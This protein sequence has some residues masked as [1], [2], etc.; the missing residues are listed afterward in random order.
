MKMIAKNLKIKSL[1]LLVS[2]TLIVACATT[3]PIEPGTWVMQSP[4]GTSEL[5]E[6][7]LLRD[8]EYYL[9]A[10]GN[11]ISGVYKLAQTDLKVVQPDNPRMSGLVWQL[12]PDKT[13]TL[14]QEA[15]V[16]ISSRRLVSA[17]LVKQP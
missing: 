5:V 4:D 11:P 8:S 7:R 2:A 16:Q 1:G 12:N 17:T 13:L 3:R 14:V 10:P 9:N 6:I 15:P